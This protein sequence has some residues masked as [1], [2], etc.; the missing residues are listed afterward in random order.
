MARYTKNG[1]NV[2]N[3]YGGYTVTWYC[4][5]VADITVTD[6]TVTVVLNIYAHFNDSA[7]IYGGDCNQGIRLS[8]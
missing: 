1:P 4:K 2:T 3:T 7:H 5:Q 6:T 8:Q